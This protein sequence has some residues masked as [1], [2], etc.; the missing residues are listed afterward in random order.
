[1]IHAY[2]YLRLL[3]IPSHPISVSLSLS[4]THKIS[5][6]NG[7]FINGVSVATSTTNPNGEPNLDASNVLN[8]SYSVIGGG[9]DNVLHSNHAVIAGGHANAIDHRGDWATIGGGYPIE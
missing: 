1:M 5:V 2:W 4:H 3:P 9:D 8:G 7:L 6:D